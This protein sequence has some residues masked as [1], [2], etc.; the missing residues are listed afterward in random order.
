[1]FNVS[2]LNNDSVIVK[3]YILFE[4]VT[5]IIHRESKSNKWYDMEGIKKTFAHELLLF[6]TTKLETKVDIKR[7]NFLIS[8]LSNLLMVQ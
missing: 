2:K 3:L 8:T 7:E 1:M 6:I 4:Y 5:K